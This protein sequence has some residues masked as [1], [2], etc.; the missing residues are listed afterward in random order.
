MKNIQS[1]PVRS[2]P[3]SRNVGWWLL[4]GLGGL[5]WLGRGTPEGTRQANVRLAEVRARRSEE[6]REAQRLDH[7]LRTPLGAMAIALELLNS[8]DATTEQEALD[9][10]R[11][12][13]ARLTTLTDR[14]RLLSQRLGD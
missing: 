10:L 14:L 1:S 5:A 3:R 12:Q 6:A 11:R 4:V 7:E 9:V 13:L 8:G 2:V